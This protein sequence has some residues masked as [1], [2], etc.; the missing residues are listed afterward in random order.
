VIDVSAS[1]V[2]GHAS[3]PGWW[4]QLVIAVLFGAV[5]I[6]WMAFL[7]TLFQTPGLEGPV[8]IAPIAVVVTVLS[9]TALPLVRWDNRLGYLAAVLAG[10]AAVGGITLYQTGTFGPTRSAPA[11][12][13]FA[14]VGAALVITSVAAWRNRPSGR[15]GPSASTSR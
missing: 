14:L 3:V 5:T 6:G 1:S 15:P 2:G 4:R 13:L 8:E 9:S 11:A 10:F 7:A 12:Y